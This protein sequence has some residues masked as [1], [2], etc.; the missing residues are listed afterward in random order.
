MLSMWLGMLGWEAVYL[1]AALS[2]LN[3]PVLGREYIWISINSLRRGVL[4]Q[5]VLMFLTGVAGL[6]GG[7]AGLLTGLYP[8]GD[9]F[10]VASF[11]TTYHLLGGYVSTYVKK[12]S[13]EA[14]RR[15]LRIRP[16]RVR[17]C[18]EN[19]VMDIDVR[20][21]RPGDVLLID[22][23]ESIP[24]DGVLLSEY[25][26]VDESIVTGESLP[27]DKYRGDEV[28]SGSINLANP[29]LVR[30]ERGYDESYLSLL[31]RYIR[32][33]RALK[34]PILTLLD[35]VLRIYILFVLAVAA[36]SLSAWLLIPRLMGM[37]GGLVRPIYTFMTVLVMGYPCALGMAVPLAI[38]K[39][40]GTAAERGILIRNGDSIQVLSSRPFLVLDKTGTMTLG[41]PVVHRFVSL[42]GA[43]EAE[44]LRLAACLESFSR[45]PVAEAIYS[46]VLD[47]F[48]EVECGGVDDIDVYP[49]DGESHGY[50]HVYV[51]VDGVV[52]GLFL[53][54]D[55]PR[56]GLGE[57]LAEVRK[58]VSGVG[59]LTGDSRSNTEMLVRGLRLDWVY[60]DMKPEDK[61][62]IIR[63]LQREGH[64]VVMVGDG[65][66]DAP[67]V[68][69]ADVGV[70]FGVETDITAVNSDVVILSD[71][72]DRVVEMF[73][74]SRRMY[75]RTKTNLFLAFIYNG[76]GVPLA[77]LGLIQPYWAMIFMVLSVSS[78]ILNSLRGL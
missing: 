39:G 15:L 51:A 59:L 48:G 17:V 64:R 53:L 52:A 42:G 49:G 32:E 34:P 40:S 55:R 74:L 8:P 70:A 14:V 45:H 69:M 35:R 38:I 58:Y 56:E 12:R 29:I 54:A 57:A 60:T 65:F 16:R 68:S 22:V 75:R 13:D 66:N 4:N 47:R 10:G 30:V 23:G 6:L 20:D 72:F 67:S 73:R 71:D 19:A 11:V 3:F 2:S 37:G 7:L 31:I 63:R 61:A 21:A 24:L 50:R 33:A 5:H 77:A 41:R 36:L 25:A 43:G 44:V 9:F 78:L 46:Y 18:R 28:V 1:N 76:L 26:S 27:V 62:S